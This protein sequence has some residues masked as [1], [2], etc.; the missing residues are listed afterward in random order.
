MQVQEGPGWR[1]CLDSNRGSFPVLIGGEGW[2][3]ELEA[4][5]ARALAEGC[6][7]LSDELAVL[8]D[9]L[10]PEE[11]L[12]LELERGP[13]WLELEGRPQAWRLRFVLTPGP[14]ARG[15]EAGWSEAAS[16][17]VVAALRQ[18][19]EFTPAGQLSP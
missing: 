3:V 2:A 15:V 9:R 19:P 6:S 10:M 13:L 7:R 11:E 18:I 12:S 5:E 1:L 14:G 16:Q 17:A 4:D 8:A